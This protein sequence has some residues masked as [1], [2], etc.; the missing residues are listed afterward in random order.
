MI[1]ANGLPSAGPSRGGEAARSLHAE[2]RS[3]LPRSLLTLARAGERTEAL[4]LRAALRLEGGEFYSAGA[5][6]LM[7][8]LHGVDIGAYSYGECFVPGAF[9]PGTLVGRYVSIADGV[10]A[11]GRNHPTDQLSMHPFF[12]NRRLG[13]VASDTLAFAGLRI[14]SDAWLGLRAII[15]PGCRRVGLGAVVAA[16]AVV[17]HDV[18][19]FAVVA[20]APARVLRYRFAEGVRD[21]V[22][23]SR[24]WELSVGDLV[25]HAAAMSM[26]VASAAESHPLLARR[27]LRTPAASGSAPSACR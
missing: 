27:E 15:T 6:D 16:G 19:D 18:P 14:E 24:W 25:R 1:A 5:R 22:R 26:P 21:A 12:F 13:Y 2:L 7:R 3:R 8:R 10:R 11:L 17:T 23:R 4:L 9:P 20:G